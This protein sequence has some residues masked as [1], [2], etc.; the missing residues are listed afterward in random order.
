MNR[1]RHNLP[2]FLASAVL[3]LACASPARA[4]DTEIFFT[5]TVSGGDANLMLILDTSGSMDSI[6]DTTPGPYDS[7]LTYSLSGTGTG[8]Y[9]T[10]KCERGRVYFRP[11]D[12]LNTT[13]PTSCD[14]LSYFTYD[15]SSPTTSQNKCKASFSALQYGKSEYSGRAGFYRDYFIRWSGSGSNKSWVASLNSGT[16][17]ECFSD[18]GTDGNL[19]ASNPYPRSGNSSDS[20]GRWGTAAQQWWTNPSVPR[21]DSNAGTNVGKE[22]ILWS[23]NYIGW[24][25]NAAPA[26]PK[27]RMEAMK[28]AATNLLSTITGMNVGLMRYDTN[29]QGGMVLAPALPIDE[30]TH[31]EDLI[32]LVNDLRHAGTTP[33][34]ETLFEAMRYYSGG[35]VH[36]GN[37]SQICTES[38][39]ATCASNR[40]QN[41]PSVPT[42]R[43]PATANGANY[44][45]PADASCQNNYIVFLTDGLPYSDTDADTLIEGTGEGRLGLTCDAS[46]PP[47]AQSPSTSGRCLKAL[48]KYMYENDLRADVESVQNVRTYFIG[49]GGDITADAFE[50]LNQAAQAGGGRA[51][52]PNSLVELEGAFNTIVNEVAEINVTFT[53]PS[54]AVNAFNRTQTLDDL[55]VSVFQPSLGRHWPGNL[56]KYTIRDGI[57]RDQSGAAAVGDNG[58][59]R[60]TARSFWSSA[61]DGSD[62]KR[63]GAASLIPNADQRKLY[64]Y[65]GPRPA[66]PVDLTASAQQFNTTN[67]TEALLGIGEAGD[68]TL[69]DLVNWARGMDVRDTDPVNGNNTEPRR[70]MGDPIHAQPSVI[71]YG[72][73]PETPDPYDAVIFVPTNDGYLH[74]VDGKTGE[75]LWAF[76]PREVLPLLKGL[77]ENPTTTTKQYALDGEIRA[78]RY[79]ING[80]GI[81]DEEAGDRIIL[82]FGQGR[83]GSHYYA[84]DVTSRDRPKLLW[85]LGPSELP[86]VGQTWSPP[87]IARVNIRDAEQNSQKLVLIFG[88]GYDVAEDGQFFVPSSM[89]GNRI[90]M[91]DATRGTLLWSA[92]NDANTADLVLP[93]M[94]HSIPGGVTV[95]DTNQDGYADRMYVG[96]MAAQLWRFDITNGNRADTLVAGGVIASLGAKRLSEN[97]PAPS[98]QNARRFY[99]APDVAAILLPGLPPFLNV[100]IGSGYRGHPLNTAIQDRFYSIRDLRP[101][102]RM[103]QQQYNELTPITDAQL[104]DITTDMTP[105]IPANA[106]G[107]KLLLNQ[108]GNAWQ[109]EK[110]LSAANTFDNKIFFTTYS[111]PD[112]SSPSPNSCSSSSRGTGT[113]RAYIVNVLNGTPGRWQNDTGTG[114]EG[115][116]GEDEEDS[117]PRPEDRFEEL[118]QGGIAPQVSFLFPEP[119][120]VVCLSGVEV[121]SICTNFN[122]RIK[123]YWRESTAP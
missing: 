18:N 66:S 40:K 26:D 75:E 116:T 106:P 120:K 114:G 80:D 20:N 44:D 122:S 73:T 79:D 38:S 98:E 76:V 21:N 123:T 22:Y 28:E 39:S 55:Y 50:Y 110:V 10:N 108:P 78:L 15:I 5:E 3:V 12:P 54:V 103:T 61:T 1:M 34:S 14:G 9:D 119:N 7:T 6:A 72:G 56:K 8:R 41:R 63:G 117:Q 74:A 52:Q 89:V 70:V 4:D 29:G 86:G 68:P 102:T 83:G 92:G 100:A 43:S 53:S 104:V 24:A 32:A 35:P 71:V 96:D 88:G 94:T 105:T 2:S 107:W 113:N 27:T 69:E 19:S 65:T 91:V 121:L 47:G 90:F 118:D 36:F 16:A 13:P 46:G 97:D 95:L 60:S 51:F 37:N 11:N 62:V 82:Y 42:S 58:F 101:F 93:K 111:P 85:T 33:L 57:I 99:N 87:T 48:T 59:F 31:R 30:G 112:R 77:Y 49:F 84:I 45:S 23:P 67:V 81:I 115:E 109:G 25:R 64:T 17:V